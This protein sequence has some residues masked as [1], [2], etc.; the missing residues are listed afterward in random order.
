MDA[1]IPV[2]VD[3]LVRNR[4]GWKVVL[5]IGS[6]PPELTVHSFYLDFAGNLILQH[7]V[8][9]TRQVYARPYHIV[10][11]GPTGWIVEHKL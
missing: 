3:V 1:E 4:H 6:P 8:T 9:K 2:G 10:R 11:P 7:H 5:P